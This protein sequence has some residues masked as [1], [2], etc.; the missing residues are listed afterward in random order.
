MHQDTER[1]VIPVAE[2]SRRWREILGIDMLISQGL[3]GYDRVLS[4]HH[5]VFFVKSPTICHDQW[6]GTRLPPREW[7]AGSIGFLPAGSELRCSATIKYDESLM[8]ID[9]EMFRAAIRGDC[10]FSAD[11]SLRYDILASEPA[12]KLAA[13]IDSIAQSEIVHDRMVGETIAVAL[14]AAVVEGL[15]GARMKEAPG[16][17]SDARKRRV[18]G[19]I[20]TH[21]GEEIT[22]AALAD[23]A[24]LSQY[25]FSRK[26]GRAFGMS[27]LRYVWAR[28]VRAAQEMLLNSASPLADIAAACG[29]SSQS[30]FTT[31]F[32]A[33]I[34]A[35][36]AR[37]RATVR[38]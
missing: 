17:L 29:F 20:E 7:P 5:T 11:A 27:P 16:A 4:P 1:I 9:D 15:I 12:S 24:A 6:Q 36:P 22:L 28:R 25:H 14:A 32:K 35:T 37:Y 19:Y 38:A 13:V 23:V 33:A 10:N 26:F 34:G 3:L 31:M 30:H 18:L 21:L 8:H 2:R